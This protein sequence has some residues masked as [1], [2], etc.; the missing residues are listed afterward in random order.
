MLGRNS[1]HLLSA[2]AQAEIRRRPARYTACCCARRRTRTAS[3]RGVRRCPPESIAWQHT[4][5][6]IS[7]GPLSIRRYTDD[8]PLLLLLLLVVLHRRRRRRRRRC[9]RLRHAGSLASMEQTAGRGNGGGREGWA[10]HVLTRQD[11]GRCNDSPWISHRRF[12]ETQL[13]RVVT[14]NSR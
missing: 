14:R 6:G 13:G 10:R 9:R 11:Y 2:C 5:C 4:V 7:T 12:A 1:Y 8:F 3:P